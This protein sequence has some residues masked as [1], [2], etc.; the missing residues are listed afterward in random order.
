[1]GDGILAVFKQPLNATVAALAVQK[2]IREYSAMRVEQEKF[3]ARIGLNTG[4][5]IRRGQRHLRRG[6]ERRL[7]H[8]GAAHRGDIVLT[9]ATYEEIKDYVRCT[10]GGKV[11]VKGI[12]DPIMAYS[13]KEVTVD[14]KAVAE[15][16]TGKDASSMRDA[17]L[18]KLK[19]SIFVPSFQPPPDKTEH[20]ELM[21]RLKGVFSDISRVVEELASDY[22]DEYEFKKYLQDKWNALMK[23]L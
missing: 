4:P 20:A 1:M 2:K 17:S 7:P 11:P 22:H 16:S 18:Q 10:D 23:S 19:E 3:Q 15:A 5:V 6:R 14:L 12:K 21:S 8:A 9:E 13:A